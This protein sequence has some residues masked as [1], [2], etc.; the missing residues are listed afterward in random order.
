MWCSCRVL[1]S[2]GNVWELNQS[3]SRAIKKRH[4]LKSWLSCFGRC[5]LLLHFY[6]R[7]T[8]I[9]MQFHEIKSK[10]VLC[11]FCRYFV[12]ISI[13]VKLIRNLKWVNRMTLNKRFVNREPTGLFRNN[14]WNAK[15]VARICQIFWICLLSSCT[16][17]MFRF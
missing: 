6:S 2:C 15:Y 13:P 11:M 16:R 1:T 17:C 9:C 5:S 10:Y 7:Q 8:A 4:V 12:G 14:L 3:P